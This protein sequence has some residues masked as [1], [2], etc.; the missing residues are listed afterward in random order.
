MYPNHVTQKIHFF[1]FDVYF[2]TQKNC[3][4]HEEEKNVFTKF[5]IFSHSIATAMDQSM[6]KKLF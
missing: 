4:F 1:S 5:T 3:L 6:K 2:G